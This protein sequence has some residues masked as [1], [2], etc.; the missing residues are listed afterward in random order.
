MLSPH[1]GAVVAGAAR[2]RPRPARPANADVALGDLLAQR[3][4]E[5]ADAELR[6]V[7]DAA[8][9]AG[10]PA[11]HRADV[12]HVGHPARAV[13]GRREQVGER[14]VG[15]VQQPEHVQL[16]PSAATPRRAPRSAGPSSITPALLTSTSSRPSRATA[17]STTSCACS[18]CVTSASRTSAVPPVP[19][20]ARRG[21]RA[22]RGGAR[23]RRPR[24]RAPR[25]RGRWP[26]RCRSGAGHD[27]TVP[28]RTGVL[29]GVTRAPR[30]GGC[31][32]GRCARGSDAHADRGRAADGGRRPSCGCVARLGLVERCRAGGPPGPPD[33]AAAARPFPGDHRP[34]VDG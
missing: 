4:A 32:G 6:R 5:R 30:V 14:G 23:R 17:C 28:A 18:C 16:R 11:G 26:R 21:P 3:L 27:A 9:G 25:G 2:S 20:C 34:Q 33:R 31:A 12:H 10:D 19:R 22:G 15:A 7:V 1:L 13:L 8:A 24:R 29:G